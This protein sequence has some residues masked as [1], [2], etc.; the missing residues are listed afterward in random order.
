M[1]KFLRTKSI[2]AS[3]TDIIA[4]AEKTIGILSPYPKIHENFLQRLKEA[5]D[6]GIKINFILG[7]KK[8]IPNDQYK[9]LAGF[10]NIEIKF[11]KE[12]HAKCYYNE[13]EMVISSMNLHTYSEENNRE[14]GVLISLKDN[15]DV[16]NDA[17]KEIESII[18]KAVFVKEKLS[19]NQHSKPEEKPKKFVK[20]ESGFCIRCEKTIKY[21]Y[22]YPYC[23]DCYKTWKKFKDRNYVEKVCH[24]CRQEWNTTMNRPLCDMCFDENNKKIGN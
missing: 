24:S 23:P 8:S 22:Y 16:Y 19:S 21:D 5:D 18:G 15:S 9:I 6:R 4:D 13:K 17:M 10:K 3:I 2:S 20:P 11:L 12:L 14:M 7:K 1:A